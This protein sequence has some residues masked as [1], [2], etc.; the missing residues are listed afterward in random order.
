MTYGSHGSVIPQ[1]AGAATHAV[2]VDPAD[3]AGQLRSACQQLSHSLSSRPGGEPWMT[4]LAPH[5]ID[6]LIATGNT[7]ELRELLTRYD[8]VV[9]NPQLRS[10]EAAS[11]FAT[12]R[13]LLRQYVSQGTQR[14]DPL[15]DEPMR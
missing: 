8:G 3:L 2:P 12:T 6:Q 14:T 10:I 4:Y 1:A 7:A 13:N 5:Q 9:G 11:G 15:V